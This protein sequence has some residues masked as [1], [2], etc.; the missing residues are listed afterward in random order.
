MTATVKVRIK[1]EHRVDFLPDSPRNMRPE[2]ILVAARAQGLPSKQHPISYH[3]H[4]LVI[5]QHSPGAASYLTSAAPTPKRRTV[6]DCFIR[7]VLLAGQ[8]HSV[9]IRTTGP[10]CK[11]SRG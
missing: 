1:S 2:V 5:M 7:T 10:S 9:C 4:S 11:H 3:Q 8:T 6:R